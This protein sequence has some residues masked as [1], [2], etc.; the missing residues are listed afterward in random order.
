M[1]F[2]CESCLS[3]L[4]S[5]HRHVERSSGPGGLKKANPWE[6]KMAAE[7]ALYFARQGCYPED[8]GVV[9]LVSAVLDALTQCAYAG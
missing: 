7:M 5:D 1:Y 2:S 3:E 4:T 6:A 9:V 8:K